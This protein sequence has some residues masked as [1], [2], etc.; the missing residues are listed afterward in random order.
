M[1]DAGRVLERF[2]PGNAMTKRILSYVAATCMMLLGCATPSTSQVTT[3]RAAL[4]CTGANRCWAK[5][6][7]KNCTARCDVALQFDVIEILPNVRGDVSWEL[8]D[9][10]YEFP[11]NGIVVDDA[12]GVFRCRPE[13]NRK[14]F[15]CANAH[16]P[17]PPGL[18]VK[19][20]KYTINLRGALPVNAYDPFMVN[21]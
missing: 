15:I 10:S 3:E 21:D 19:V 8:Q 9:P 5:V 6:G 20:Y 16:P 4:K 2:S 18:G 13:Q 14:V 7:V 11:D 12:E 17:N 1:I